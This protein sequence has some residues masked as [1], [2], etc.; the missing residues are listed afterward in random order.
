MGDLKKLKA[1][2]ERSGVRAFRTF[3][4]A[5]GAVLLVGMA[6]G[7]D[8]RACLATAGAAGVWSF[9]QN[10]GEGGDYE[11]VAGRHRAR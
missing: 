10:L 1:D 7:I 4:Q 6:S 2:A 8:W 11:A 5:L 9:A 3:W